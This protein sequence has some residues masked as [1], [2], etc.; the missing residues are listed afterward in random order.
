MLRDGTTAEFAFE[1]RDGSGVASFRATDDA[2]QY[3]YSSTV[4]IPATVNTYDYNGDRFQDL[5]LVRKSDGHLLFYPGKGDGALGTAV[6]RGGGWNAMDVV[7]AGDLTGDGDP[8]LLARDTRTGNLYTYPGDGAGNFEPHILAG[9]GGTR[10]ASSPRRP[11]STGTA[12]STC[13]PSANP[14]AG[15][16]STPARATA[17]SAPGPSRRS[18][19]AA[20]GG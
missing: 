20:T 19:P 11:T 7:M 13:S 3:D 18:R 10:S 1:L 6:S 8:D 17:P 9:G 16:C 5:Y 14:T 4:V 2:G 12:P 15:C